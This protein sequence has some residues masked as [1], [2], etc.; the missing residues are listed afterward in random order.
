MPHEASAP[1]TLEG[2]RG[3]RP[4]LPGIAAILRVAVRQLQASGWA[5]H[6][7]DTAAGDYVCRVSH[8][9]TVTPR[10]PRTNG[11]AVEG[12]DANG[13]VTNFVVNGGGIE[14]H[15]HIG[16]A[17]GWRRVEDRWR[18]VLQQTAASIEAL[19]EASSEVSRMEELT[20]RIY[21]RQAELISRKIIERAEGLLG[22]PGCADWSDALHRHVKGVLK[23]QPLPEILSQ[24]L[25]EVEQRLEARDVIA[26]AKSA[27]RA[28]EG[29]TEEQA[30]RY[31]REE[32]RNS[33]E[34]LT[35]V[36]RRVLGQ[37]AQQWPGE[38]ESSSA[39]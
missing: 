8:N 38:R 12:G 6:E 32:S 35:E 29:L 3:S 31:L 1:G 23:F 26:A 10:Q 19:L 25:Q 24:Q 30:Y 36:A 7:W 22:D 13:A 17:A 20:N 18:R 34:P 16:F 28:R 33:R 2:Q 9:L 39:A 27:L 21:E 4:Y 37:D 15:V 11:G 14:G 5:Y